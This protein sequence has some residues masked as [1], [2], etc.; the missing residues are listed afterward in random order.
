[1]RLKSRSPGCSSVPCYIATTSDHLFR[2]LLLQDSSA[3][4]KTKGKGVAAHKSSN[5]EKS[6][7]K[8]AED[9]RAVHLV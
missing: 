2:N 9:P 3:S 6:T 8:N 1:M 4:S 5:N 7:S